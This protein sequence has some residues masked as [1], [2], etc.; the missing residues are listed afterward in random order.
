MATFTLPKD[1]GDLLLVEV[2]PGWT[3][4]K[5]TLL[6]GADY[7][8]GTV[9]TKLEGKYQAIDPA[10]EDGTANAC[11]V[12]AERVDARA[13]DATGVVLARG[14]VVQINE[15]IWP[16]A[17]TEPQKTAALDQLNAVGIVARSVL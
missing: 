13:A 3:K 7:P 2:A 5:A 6:A 8:M 10:I 17:L 4:E 11:A 16:D 12:L 9:L 15:L 14:A 1:L